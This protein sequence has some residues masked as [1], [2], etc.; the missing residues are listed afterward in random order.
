MPPLKPCP[1]V[2]RMIKKLRLALEIEIIL[3]GGVMDQLIEVLSAPEARASSSS[4]TSERL[5]GSRHHG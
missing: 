4:P 1:R 2:A 3:S 5:S